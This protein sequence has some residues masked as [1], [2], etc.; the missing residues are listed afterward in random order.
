MC[1]CVCVCVCVT[2]VR[3]AA[4]HALPPCGAVGRFCED[5][6]LTKLF[7][8][9]GTVPEVI[10]RDYVR[11]MMEGLAYLHSRN[12]VHCDIKCANILRGKYVCAHSHTL[13]H[14]CPDTQ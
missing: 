10:A 2:M 6:A 3:R 1:L 7:R 4:A 12:V 5:G 9:G 8:K 14:S 11:Q 13:T